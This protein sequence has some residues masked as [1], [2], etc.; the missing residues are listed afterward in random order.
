MRVFFD[1]N[2]LIAAFVSRGVCSEVFEHCLVGHVV[3]TSKP[4]LAEFRRT[5]EGK[6]DF[7]KSNTRRAV[8]F[9]RENSKQIGHKPLPSPVSRDLDDDLILAAAAEGEVDCILS[10]DKDLLDLKEY[11]GIPILKPGDFWKFEKDKVH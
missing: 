6:F 11:E 7:R 3:C 1:T 5:L 9:L 8:A 2:V 4:V 10:G